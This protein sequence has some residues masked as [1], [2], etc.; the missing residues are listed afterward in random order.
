MNSSKKKNVSVSIHSLHR[1]KM[2]QIEAIRDKDKAQEEEMN[3]FINIQKVLFEQDDQPPTKTMSLD[4]IVTEKLKK[5]A[6]LDE[7]IASSGIACPTL[8]AKRRRDELICAACK[9]TDTCINHDDMMLYCSMCNAVSFVHIENNNSNSVMVGTSTQSP[10]DI[11]Y[12][13]AKRRAHLSDWLMTVQGNKSVE[14]APKV[15]DYVKKELVKMRLLTTDDIVIDEDKI[16]DTCVHTI[17]KTGKFGKYYDNAPFIRARITGKSSVFLPASIEAELKTLFDV[18]ADSY[19]KYK[20]T[21]DGKTL[22]SY[23]FIIRKLL[24]KLNAHEHLVKFKLVKSKNKLNEYNAM[25]RKICLAHGWAF[26]ASC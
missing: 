6:Q 3:Y 22:T 1:E 25:W 19:E 18:I 9:S 12:T 24:E 11:N 2:K 17:L 10:G 20:R 4:D 8:P 7:Y 15:Y 26:T 21:D 14:I 5:A 23:A 16:T 13:K